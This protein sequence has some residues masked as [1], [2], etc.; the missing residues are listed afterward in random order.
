MHYLLKKW[1]LHLKS[2]IPRPLPLGRK[3]FEHWTEEIIE[4]SGVPSNPSTRFC[5]A[6]MVLHGTKEGNYTQRSF[7]KRLRKF[8]ANEVAM[9]I[10]TELK[11][12]R[13]AALKQDNKGEATTLKV[14]GNET[15]P[16]S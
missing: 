8:A 7:A 12:Q 5:V 9:A 1:F 13:D 15:T 3:E 10:T 4:L 2:L 14:V 11:G 16:K 6:G